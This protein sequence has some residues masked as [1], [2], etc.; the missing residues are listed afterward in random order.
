[1]VRKPWM[2]KQKIYLVL[3]IC[4]EAIWI[5]GSV[6]AIQTHSYPFYYD[7][8]YFVIA[9]FFGY[10]IYHYSVPSCMKVIRGKISLKELKD[11]L[12]KE[13]FVKLNFNTI[14]KGYLVSDIC[15][16]KHWVYIADTYIP[17]KMISH[18]S[19][20][21]AGKNS[22]IYIHTTRAQEIRVADIPSELVKKFV[23]ILNKGIPEIK[24]KPNE[25]YKNFGKNYMN[26][27]KKEYRK[28]SKAQ[29]REYA[30]I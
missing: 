4:M 29:F 6:T 17:R 18:V 15:V 20:Q 30:N 8:I 10:L 11:L 25:V 16:S 7:L 19:A 28:M 23:R 1:M 3:C 12:S 9:V 2:T 5:F 22:V 14:T 13:K 21:E 24:T 26:I 27:S